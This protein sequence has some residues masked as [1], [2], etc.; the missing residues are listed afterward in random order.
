MGVLSKEMTG[1]ARFVGLSLQRLQ[2]PQ[3]EIVPLTATGRNVEAIPK[4]FSSPEIELNK[5]LCSHYVNVG[6]SRMKP[7]LALASSLKLSFLGN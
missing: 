7:G 6:F 2:V 3:R 5:L 4:D 1:D